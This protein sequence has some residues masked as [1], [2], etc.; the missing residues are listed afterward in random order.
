VSLGGAKSFD[1][2]V[3]PQIRNRFLLGV[4]EPL[5]G[6]LAFLTG[7]EEKAA[8]PA[9]VGFAPDV[10]TAHIRGNSG[11]V[12]LERNQVMNFAVSAICSQSLRNAQTGAVSVGENDVTNF[13]NGFATRVIVRECGSGFAHLQVIAAFALLFERSG[14]ESV[15]RENDVVDVPTTN[16]FG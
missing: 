4:A 10:S 7:A 6:M 2:N 5:G 11:A 15:N 3:E 8:V 14:I 16:L 13:K 9:D 1:A 12:R